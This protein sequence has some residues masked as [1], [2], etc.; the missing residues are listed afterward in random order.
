MRWLGVVG[1]GLSLHNQG[2]PAPRHRRRGLGGGGCARKR[3]APSR[4][5]KGEVTAPRD[6]PGPPGPQCRHG[7]RRR[8]PPS[9]LPHAPSSAPRSRLRGSGSLQSLGEETR[10]GR[11]GS[12]APLRGRGAGTHPAPGAAQPRARQFRG[13][14]GPSPRVRDS[15]GAEPA[16][17]LCGPPCD[18]RGRWWGES[19]ARPA[20]LPRTGSRARGRGGG[21][22][23]AVGG[24]AGGGGTGRGAPRAPA[25]RANGRPA[26]GKIAIYGHVL[27]PRAPPGRARP[28]LRL[29]RGGGGRGRSRS[30]QPARAPCLLAA[31]PL[32][33]PR[34]AAAV[35]AGR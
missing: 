13:A 26:F 10:R 33:P 8:P 29:N 16:G 21:A 7:D 14:A 22:G 20:S 6:S 15:P 5:E 19:P 2:P 17:Q 23:G 30:P 9:P 27:G 31:P 28:P 1:R 35:S 3:A 24:G 25:G 18:P 32:A 4:R 12:E 34:P 11:A